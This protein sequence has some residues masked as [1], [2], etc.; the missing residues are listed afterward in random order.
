M[1]KI[2]MGIPQL[3][4]DS[5]RWLQ[6][7]NECIDIVNSIDYQLETIS[8]EALRTPML[9][10]EF[11]KLRELYMQIEKTLTTNINTINSFFEQQFQNYD[12]LGFE[13]ANATGT[14]GDSI[15]VDASNVTGTIAGQETNI[16]NQISE[17]LGTNFDVNKA[18]NNKEAI[19][20]QTLIDNSLANPLENVGHEKINTG[21]KNREFNAVFDGLANSGNDE[22]LNFNGNP[23]TKM[24]IFDNVN[25]NNIETEDVLNKNNY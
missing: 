13:M 10:K 11:D 18:K 2:S 25:N 23:K 1:N 3:K 12:K 6:L 7:E 5:T 17:N 22:L 16:A 19:E 24:D 8:N 14:V 20:N 9:K 4:Y 21:N 15:N